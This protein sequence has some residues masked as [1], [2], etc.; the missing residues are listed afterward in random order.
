MTKEQLQIEE[1]SKAIDGINDMKSFSST[2]YDLKQLMNTASFVKEYGRTNEETMIISQLTKQIST[3]ITIRRRRKRM[4]SAVIGVA[5]AAFLFAGVTFRIP[6]DIAQQNNQ[7]LVLSPQAPGIE[8]SIAADS[9]VNKLTIEQPVTAQSSQ[10]A[11]SVTRK[12]QPQ[13]SLNRANTVS[14]PNTNQGQS[15]QARQSVVA[16]E[17][18]KPNRSVLMILPDRAADSVI[19]EA[20]GTVRQVYGKNTDKELIITQRSK[21]VIEK[22]NADSSMAVTMI[23]D[24]QPKAAAATL[25][26]VTRTVNDVEIVVEGRQDQTEL[27][28]LADSLVPSS[29]SNSGNSDR[30]NKN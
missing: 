20:G 28:K 5:A 21:A 1:L 30:S 29:Q 2:D 19:T 23:K 22:A 12:A 9:T 26:K 25:N 14:I 11:A 15:E 3:E 17:T 27:E 13:E 6:T 7:E 24:Q 8:K 10:P 4:I 18:T 16:A